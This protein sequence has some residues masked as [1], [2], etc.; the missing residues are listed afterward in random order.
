VCSKRRRSRVAHN[1]QLDGFAVNL[2]RFDFEVNANG[3]DV[4]VC[5]RVVGKAQQQTFRKGGKKDF[6]KGKKGSKKRQS[7][8]TALADARVANQEDF[9]EMV[10]AP[11]A[12]MQGQIATTPNKIKV[13]I[14]NWFFS[15]FPFFF[16]F[17]F[18][19][20]SR[21]DQNC[22]RRKVAGARTNTHKPQTRCARPTR[23]AVGAGQRATREKKMMTKKQKMG[24]PNALF[25]HLFVSRS[26]C[27]PACVR[28]CVQEEDET[29]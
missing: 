14:K 3:A 2:E 18:F 1:L 13:Q 11:H 10:A 24:F 23:S 26:V 25:S 9:E 27:V 22:R 8:L 21:V 5:P 19:F 4:R 15:L 17:F 6:C 16:F 12:H 7:D 28:L 29:L 20:S